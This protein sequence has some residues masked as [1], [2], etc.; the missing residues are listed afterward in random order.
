MKNENFFSRIGKLDVDMIWD[1]DRYVKASPGS[2]LQSSDNGL[3]ISDYLGR[4]AGN[5]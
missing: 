4:K 2:T 1:D 3:A 5:F